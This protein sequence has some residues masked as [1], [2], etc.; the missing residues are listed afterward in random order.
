MKIFENFE[1]RK[2]NSIK[3]E[4]KI[5]ENFFLQFFS[6]QIAFFMSNLKIECFQLSFDVHIVHLGKKL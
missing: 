4:T 1:F 5:L 2:K 6:Q 3:N